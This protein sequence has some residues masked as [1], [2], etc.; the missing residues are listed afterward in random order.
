MIGGEKEI[1]L[2]FNIGTLK[3]VG[4]L[5]GQDPFTVKAPTGEFKDIEPFAKIV[6]HA[7]IISN[8]RS[9]KVPIDFEQSD[10][11]TWFDLLTMRDLADIIDCYNNPGDSAPAVNG[12]VV[13]DTQP[14]VVL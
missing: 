13:K 3:A 12:E 1:G 7:A 6:F 9:R 4:E 11:D 8:Y 2:K 14:G 5:T 10:V